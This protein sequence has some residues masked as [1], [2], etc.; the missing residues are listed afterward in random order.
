M[1]IAPIFGEQRVAGILI[2]ALSLSIKFHEAT[3][4]IP[5]L[6]DS[7]LDHVFFMKAGVHGITLV[8]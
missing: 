5:L 6:G 4:Y 3:T 1:Y 8:S 2:Q 7:M